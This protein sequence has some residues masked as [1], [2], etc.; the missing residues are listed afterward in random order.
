MLERKYEDTE[1]FDRLTAQPE[2]PLETSLWLQSFQGDS[3]D[4]D[5]I[6][7]YQLAHIWIYLLE[8]GPTLQGGM[9]PAPLS[10]LEIKA[11]MHS[12]GL[13]LSPWEVVLLRKCSIEWMSAQYEAKDPTAIPPW[14]NAG[15]Q[16]ETL[17][18]MRQS[19]ADRLKRALDPGPVRK[20][21]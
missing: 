10:Y 20:K 12:T 8:V 13:S 21:K 9:G 14:T 18:T 17:S 2:I 4:D 3:E 1:W 15:N 7:P 6:L 16:Q 11:W 19:L 5:T